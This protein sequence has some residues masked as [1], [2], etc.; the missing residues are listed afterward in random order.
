MPD[1]K[2]TEKMLSSKKEPNRKSMNV[3]GF[4]WVLEGIIVCVIWAG[5]KWFGWFQN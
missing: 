5:G 4:F 2:N 3:M 1:D